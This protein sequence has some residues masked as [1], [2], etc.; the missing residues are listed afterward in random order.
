MNNEGLLYTKNMKDE[1]DIKDVEKILNKCYEQGNKTKKIPKHYEQ[2][3]ETYIQQQL[4]EVKETFEQGTAK[5]AYIYDANQI[6]GLIQAKITEVPKE[7]YAIIST[8]YLEEKYQD[9]YLKLMIKTMNKDLHTSLGVDEITIN[10]DKDE[11]TLKQTLLDCG[12]N[13]EEYPIEVD[14]WMSHYNVRDKKDQKIKRRN[15]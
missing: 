1:K 11:T 3:K 15:K 8:F 7:K 2:I 12:Y 6:V 13:G 9:K 10:L 4:K 14:F 5:I